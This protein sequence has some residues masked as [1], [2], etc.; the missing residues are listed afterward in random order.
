MENVMEIATKMLQRADSLN[1]A[2]RRAEMMSYC[3]HTSWDHEKYNNAADVLK[4][5]KHP[6]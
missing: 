3:S 4:K 6:E 1:D 2:I 5:M